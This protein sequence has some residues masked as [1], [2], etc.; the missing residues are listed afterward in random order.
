MTRD[1][2]LVLNVIG[3]MAQ[4]FVEDE[5]LPTEIA[6]AMVAGGATLTEITQ[7]LAGL[8]DKGKSY[9]TIVVDDDLR[10]PKIAKKH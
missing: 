9:V 2:Q 8:A 4:Q 1:E 6:G 10:E 3:F 7:H 5:T